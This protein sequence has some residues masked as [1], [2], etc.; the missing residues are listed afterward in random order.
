VRLLPIQ[1]T[2]ENRYAYVSREREADVYCDTDNDCLD[3]DPTTEDLCLKNGE[4]IHVH[5]CQTAADCVGGVPGAS[6]GCYDGLCVWYCGHCPDI[7]LHASNRVD[8]EDLAELL[9]RWG[10][11]HPLDPGD[12]DG[13]RFINS[14]DLSVLLMNWSHEDG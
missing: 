7:D 10:S 9:R 11:A 4:C 2:S 6:V 1:R 5:E 13:D 12:W 14:N 3:S 8:A